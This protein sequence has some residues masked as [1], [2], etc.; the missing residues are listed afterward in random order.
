M[1]RLRKTFTENLK[2][3]HKESGYMQIH[4]CKKMDIS[5]QAFHNWST[6]KMFPSPEKIELLAEFY[7][8]D[9]LE[10]F[11]PMDK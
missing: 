9:W 5:V 8:V 2:R 3:I 7:G 10:F 4:V 11:L 6:G 1:C